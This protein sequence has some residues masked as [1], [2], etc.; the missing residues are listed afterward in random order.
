MDKELAYSRVPFLIR[1]HFYA[2]ESFLQF[3]GSARVE[4]YKKGTARADGKARAAL[5]HTCA[6]SPNRVTLT[7]W[8]M[9]SQTLL[10]LLYVEMSP[11]ILH[12]RLVESWLNCKH[13]WASNSF[14]TISLKSDGRPGSRLLCDSKE[15]AN[16]RRESNQRTLISNQFPDSHLKRQAE[17]TVAID[18]RGGFRDC[19]FRR[20]SGKKAGPRNAFKQKEWV[21]ENG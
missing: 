10:M 16:T 9:S 13:T 20:H 21:R 19:C 6:G 12:F 4:C 2:V 5:L 15:D 1:N 18:D 3:A 14:M 7:G 17:K 8:Q 11:E